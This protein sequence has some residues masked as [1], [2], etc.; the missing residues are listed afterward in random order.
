MVFRGCYKGSGGVKAF[1][2]C[3]S[4]FSFS[5]KQSKVVDTSTG[6]L[7]CRKNSEMVLVCFSISRYLFH[8]GPMPGQAWKIGYLTPLQLGQLGGVSQA[9][10]TGTKFQNSVDAF[11]EF[12]SLLPFNFA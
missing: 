11:E 5:K 4:P 9:R 10:I 2:D 1:D 8:A 7:R 6:G 3:H 12:P